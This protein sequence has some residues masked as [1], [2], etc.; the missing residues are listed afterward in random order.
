MTQLTNLTH[1]NTVIRT[2]V[3]AMM[4]AS[5]VNAETSSRTTLAG[6]TVEQYGTELSDADRTTRLRAAKS[7]SAMGQA[8][9]ATLGDALHHDDPAVR[10]IAAAGLGRMGG[11]SLEDS[12]ESLKNLAKDKRSHAAQMA[13][14]F[15]LCRLG[16]TSKNLPILID[17][18]SNP[19]RGMVCAAAE[20]LGDIGPPAKDATDPLKAIHAK[21]KSGVKGGDYHIGGASMNALRKIDPENFK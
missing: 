4:F 13:A 1:A 12:R 14:S 9:G 21:N 2:V 18:L 20:L 10:Y 3:L 15:A 11:E 19:Q 17:A 8:A 16:E 7:L 5:S 6:K